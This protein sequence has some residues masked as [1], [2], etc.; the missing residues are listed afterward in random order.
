MA[1]NW[2]VTGANGYLGGEI[3]IALKNANQKVCG[4][5]RTEKGLKRLTSLGIEVMT[6]SDLNRNLNENSIFVH[7]AGKVGNYGSWDE[8]REVN[9]EWSLDLF[10]ECEKKRV[11]KFFY[12]SSV[13][14][15]GYKNRTPV[16]EIDEESPPVVYSKEFYGRSK[17]LAEN[18]LNVASANSKTDLIIL[19]PGLI[20]GK[21]TFVQKQTFFNR[22][23][24][25]DGLQRLP[26]VHV[27]DFISAILVCE[28]KS[29]SGEVYFVVG[30]E[31]I[32]VSELLRFN[33]E[34]NLIK[35]KPWY[36]GT[37]GFWFLAMLNYIFKIVIGKRKKN[38]LALIFADFLIKKRKIFYKTNK[39]KALG[40]LPK[41]SLRQ[42]FGLERK[43]ST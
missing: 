34:N 15:V 38:A 31:Q 2:V 42:E 39:I 14:A 41:M 5:V 16:N 7:C 20:Y 28:R 12:I 10:K 36:I 33:L 24:L 29:K 21:R 32:T 3:C 35:Y 4:V 18:K 11:R 13:A 26:L 37:I 1:R 6:Y 40:W 9:A 23:F 19:R 22:G 8:F 30:D 17:L 27:N 43:C 25:I